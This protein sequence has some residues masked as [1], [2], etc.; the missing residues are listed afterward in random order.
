MPAGAAGYGKTCAAFFVANALHTSGANW[1]YLP[2]GP[3]N[4]FEDYVA[5]L[6]K[7]CFGCDPL[8]FA[9]VEATSCEAL[10]VAGY[11]RI[12]PDC[13]SIE[14]GH[15]NFSPKLQRTPAATGAMYLMMRHAFETWL[16]PTNFD[17][18]GKQRVGLAS[19]TRTGERSR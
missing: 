19:L 8:F 10:G 18:Q 2:Y 11:L 4:E 17:E 13:G 5:W 14:I 6:E 1:T 16:S 9:I 7:Q 15:L 3:F 12:T